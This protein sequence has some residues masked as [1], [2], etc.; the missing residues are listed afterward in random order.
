MLG[1]ARGKPN[2][3]EF[4]FCIF[5]ATCLGN[6]EGVVDPVVQLHIS[7]LPCKLEQTFASLTFP[8]SAHFVAWPRLAELPSFKAPNLPPE[9]QCKAMACKFTRHDFRGRVDA[10]PSLIHHIGSLELWL[11]FGW[12]CWQTGWPYSGLS[13]LPAYTVQ[14]LAEVLQTWG[15]SLQAGCVRAASLNRGT[16]PYLPCLGHSGI[17][18]NAQDNCAGNLK[19]AHTMLRTAT[20]RPTQPQ[21]KRKLN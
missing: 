9:P 12:Q 13:C 1:E 17:R 5:P 15:P 18:G 10:N 16:W 3:I 4:H 11:E 2:R 6:V 21:R 7:L 14:N 20:G 8:S 19:L